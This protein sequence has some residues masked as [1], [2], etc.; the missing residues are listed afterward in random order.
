MNA[1]KLSLVL[2]GCLGSMV[3]L[4]ALAQAQT[5]QIT[6]VNAVYD[7]VR[8]GKKGMLIQIDADVNNLRGQQV[9]F[10]AYFFFANGKRLPAIPGAGKYGTPDGQVTTQ[11]KEIPLYDVTRFT[12]AELFIPYFELTGGISPLNLMYQVEIQ[13]TNGGGQN[14]LLNRSANKYFNIK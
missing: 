13:Y 3:S 9:N 14:I 6:Y 8:D 11:R 5:G 2:L 12:N 10:A 1:I 4:P 7:V